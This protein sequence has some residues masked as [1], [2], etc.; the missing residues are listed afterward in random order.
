METNKEIIT[1]EIEIENSESFRHYHNL[2]LHKYEVSFEN[3]CDLWSLV[4]GNLYY[5]KNGK[6]ISH[7][8]G[9]IRYDKNGD[10]FGNLRGYLIVLE[11]ALIEYF[12]G[13][14]ND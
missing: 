9:G 14:N 7:I 10:W 8:N 3:N 4:N 5:D 6:F 13:E 1:K 12:N 11:K 2:L